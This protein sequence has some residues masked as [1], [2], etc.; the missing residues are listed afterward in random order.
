MGYLPISGGEV[1]GRSVELVEAFVS[2]F[3]EPPVQNKSILF[4]SLAGTSLISL[5]SSAATIA[6]WSITTAFPTGAGS[7]P[8]GT[9]YSV[10]QADSGELV[11]GTSLTSVHALAAATYTSPAG[12]GS[13]Y[14]FSSNN[15]SIGDYYQASMST[16]GFESI[17]VSWDQTRSATGPTS[18]EMIF[19]VNSGANW[20]TGFAYTVLQSGGGGAPATWSTTVYNSIYTSSQS[21]L[22]AENAS[23]VLVRFRALVAGASSGSN[24]IDNVVFSGNLVPAPGAIALLG[25]AGLI[26]RRRR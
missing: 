12:N 7:V 11:A 6:S 25:L 21:L 15:W 2:L 17:S 16:S 4:L 13:T 1:I 3:R 14:A 18:F 22:G 24:R 19:S 9:T 23:S 8:V 10:G 26:G 20:S 5:S